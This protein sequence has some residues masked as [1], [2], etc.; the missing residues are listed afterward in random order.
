MITLSKNNFFFAFYTQMY[1]LIIFVGHTVL[2][3]VEISLVKFTDL[4]QKVWHFLFESLKIYPNYWTSY[5]SLHYKTLKYYQEW[6][7]YY[8][9]CYVVCKIDSILQQRK[10]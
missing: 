10:L 5:F 3:S 2:F 1:V 4:L 6:V 7:G 8:L 9:R